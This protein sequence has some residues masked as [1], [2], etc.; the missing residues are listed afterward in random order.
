MNIAEEK[1]NIPQSISK[2]VIPVGVTVN[3]DGTTIYQVIV[4]LILGV[5]RILDMCRT[6]INVTGDLTASIV[7]KRLTSLSSKDRKIAEK[8]NLS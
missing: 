2:F 6:T 4:A 3:M 5:D 1:L 8:I 7:M